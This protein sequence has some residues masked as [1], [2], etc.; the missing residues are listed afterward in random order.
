M[1]DS[2]LNVKLGEILTLKRGYDLPTD[3]RDTNGSY[4]V[5][6]SAGIT[7]RHSVAKVQPPGIVT[8]RYGTTG[9]IFFLTEPFWP[10]NTSLYVMDFKGNDPRFVYFLLQTIDFSAFSG[11]TGVP[12]VNRN[13]LHQIPVLLP[14]LA[15]QRKIAAILSTW[16]EAIALTRQL[17]AALQR[18]KQALMQ[19]LLTGAVRFPGFTDEWRDAQLGDA[20]YINPPKPRGIADE[21]EVSFIAMADVSE[22]ARLTNMVNRKYI[23]VKNG[24]TGFQDNDVLVAKITP[25]FENGKGALVNELTNGVGFGSTEFH[26]MR[27]KSELI[28]PEFIYY[29]TITHRFRGNG[30][31]NMSGSAGQKRV[32]TEF[33]R[34]YPILL[35]S[36]AE[37]R[38]IMGVLKACDDQLDIFREMIRQLEQQK[39]GLMQQ[40]LTGAVRVPVAAG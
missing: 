23:E 24:F 4:P 39:R 32:P 33:L 9:E 40:L 15:E 38:K 10:L 26:V 13:E 2:W 14:P 16:D 37:Q 5:V 20:A 22:E 7:G 21:A 27:A 34:S 8:G 19:L 18:R 11:K 6:S 17:I 25:C 35:P 29:Q 36:L 28:T 3:Q 30:E 1:S 12:G 31:A